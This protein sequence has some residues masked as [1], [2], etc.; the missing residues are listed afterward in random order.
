VIREFSR[1]VTC[2]LIASDECFLHFLAVLGP[3]RY[4]SGSAT[5]Y[6][7]FFYAGQIDPVFQIP[8][9]T[10]GKSD[11]IPGEMIGTMFRITKRLTV[12][13]AAVSLSACISHEG[14]YTP[15]CAAFAGDKIELHDGQFVWEKFTD[16]IV[17]DDDGEVINQSPGFPMRGS[18][19]VDGQ[20]VSMVSASGEALTDM[21]LREIDNRRYLL[22]AVQLGAWEKSGQNADCALVL[23]GKDGN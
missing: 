6:K 23:G 21:Y 8:R 5:W 11:R 14:S 12:I 3:I 4:L 1:D 10:P 19:R 15:A 20:K 9:Y 18:Y 16:S 7:M 17:I 13:V 22:T 2:S